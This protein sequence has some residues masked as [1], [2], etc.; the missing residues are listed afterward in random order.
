M[1]YDQIKGSPYYNVE[2]LKAEFYSSITETAYARYNNYSD[3][4]E[5]K[6]ENKIYALPKDSNFNKMRFIHSNDVL[7]LLNT[8]DAMSGYFFG[9]VDGKNSL[10]KKVKMKFVDAVIQS[11][12]YDNSKP[13]SFKP[14]EVVYYIKTTDRF[15]KAPKDQKD[16]MTSFINNNDEL[17][18][19]FKA[20]KIKFN[21][22][23]DL[24]K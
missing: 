8:E 20:N 11:S 16:I 6:K 9:I 24:I 3:T 1:I 18:T 23:V 10:Y 4:V 22:E 19:F 7:T 14:A 17:N 13:A 5:F 21:K 15:V 2:F 12:S